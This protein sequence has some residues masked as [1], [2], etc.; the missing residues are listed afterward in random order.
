MVFR[1]PHPPQSARTAGRASST[2]VRDD[3]SPSF[4]THVLALAIGCALA[5]LVS[6]AVLAPSPAQAAEPAASTTSQEYAIPAGRLSDVLARFA[7][8][9]GVQ[10][11]FD[12]QM[13]AGLNSSGLQGRYSVREG[14]DHLLTGSGYQLVSAGNG[15]YSLH[16][17]MSV[18]AAMTLAPVTVTGSAISSPNELPPAYAGGQVAR[19]GRLGILGNR[20][21]MDTPF[22][23][24]N[25]TAELMQ[26]Q[27]ARYVS[28]ALS[29]DPSAQ[30]TNLSTGY[31]GINIRGFQVPST[32][33]AFLFG[34]MQN[35]TPELPMAEAFERIE[36]LKGPNAL[37]NG[38]T[39]NVG[40]V[41][42]LV[43]KRAGE[44]PLTQITTD[45]LSES[46]L[47]GHVDIG[48]RFGSNKQ[49]GIR[50]N[51]VYRDGDTSIDHQS[52]KTQLATFGLDYRGERLRLEADVGSQRNDVHGARRVTTLNPGV[53]VP[54]APDNSN[55]WFDPAEFTKLE[56]HYG[57][58]RANTTLAT[59][60]LLSRLSEAVY[61]NE[62]DLPKTG[63]LSMLKAI[64]QQVA[65]LLTLLSKKSQLHWRLVCR[66]G[67]ILA[68]SI[69]KPHFPMHHPT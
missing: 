68:S 32:S 7:A 50:F 55:N 13:L 59:T 26:N 20:D 14:F 42:N 1:R 10:L 65:Y 38:S 53:P 33:S 35:V 34:G 19:G 60:R 3:A 62:V 17:V 48:R 2:V 4:K 49:F 37:L 51:G 47:G 45:Y 44:E 25:Y 67:L 46:Q 23:Q 36:V 43:P 31:D 63:E 30:A 28:D 5:S 6:V 9:A 11:V 66:V 54:K 18:G 12:P 41:F 22:N 8:T 69:I 52:R 56:N 40:G 27:Q 21:F 24:S 57:K 16:Q 58:F 29:N 15:G 39:D 64:W 61:R